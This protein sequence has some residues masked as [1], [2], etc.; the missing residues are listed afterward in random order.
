MKIDNL[1][2]LHTYELEETN[3]DKLIKTGVLKSQGLYENG[4]A[5]IL[6]YDKNIYV[7]PDGSTWAHI[8]H[9]NNPANGVFS[10]NGSWAT[11]YYIDADR[12]YDVEQILS[13][14]IEYEFMVKQKTTSSAA[15]TKYRWI[16]SINPVNATWT[17]VKP[18]T[19]TYITTS[20]YTNGNMGGMYYRNDSY[21]RMCIANGSSGNWFGGIGVWAAYQGGIPGYPN[22]TVTSGYVDLYAR[23]YVPTKLIKD[24]GFSSIQFIEA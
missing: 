11:G 24:K 10:S 16:Q 4:Y 8:C 1:S 5:N 19:I 14:L 2:T 21:Q 12:W 18:G 17:D 15:E 9:H 13:N 23:V 22:T 20:G 7:E 3:T 6:H